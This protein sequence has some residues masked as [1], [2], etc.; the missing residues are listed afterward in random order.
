M[1][2]GQRGAWPRTGKG[3]HRAGRRGASQTHSPSVGFTVAQQSRGEDPAPWDDAGGEGG[4]WKTPRGAASSGVAVTGGAAGERGAGVP[5]WHVPSRGGR[6]QMASTPR[7]R[8]ACGRPQQPHVAA[9]AV[10]G[11]PGPGRQ[12]C[13]AG[14]GSC[15]TPGLSESRLTAPCAAASSRVAVAKFGR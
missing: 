13:D 14:G 12:L 2:G 1:G 3:G 5:A 9:V 6:E 7:S 4:L 10:P 11:L 8:L 15:V